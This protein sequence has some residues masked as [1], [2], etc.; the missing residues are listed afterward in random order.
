MFIGES[1]KLSVEALRANKVRTFLTSLGLV[2]GNASV[3]LVVTISVT[4]RDYIL[5]QIRAIGSNI[6]YGSYQTGS[7][8][9]ATAAADFVKL[10]DISAVRQQ[11][12][13]R[14]VAATGVMTTF[15][16][17]LIEGKEK[18]VKIIGSDD[19]YASVRNLKLLAGRF[20]DQNDVLLRQK[21]A[22]L[23]E[24]LAIRLY[25]SQPSAIGQTIRIHQ[26]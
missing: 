22:L 1:L 26:L 19:Q 13:S 10:S 23:T 25:G 18:D 24:K 20:L 16:S 11:L 5:D 3:I 15:D 17:M 9:E 2:I 21:V 8:E 14:I 7:N 12:G 6:I 4:G